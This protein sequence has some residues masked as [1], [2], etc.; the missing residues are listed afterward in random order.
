MQTD[1]RTCVD[2][3]ALVETEP[4][5]TEHGNKSVQTLLRQ[6]SDIGQAG[7]HLQGAL[8]TVRPDNPCF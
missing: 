4:N 8:V 7:H 5:R 2:N 1:Q 3:Q 6:S